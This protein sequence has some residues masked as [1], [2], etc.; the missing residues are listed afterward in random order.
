MTRDEAL[1]L[2]GSHVKADN[3]KKHCLA[4]EAI[5]LELA[6]RLEQ[7]RELWGTIGLLHDLD[8]EDTKE[9]P[10]V[11]GRKTVETPGALRP[12]RRSA[13]T[14]SCGITPKRLA[15]SGRPFSTTL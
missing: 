4:T 2:L 15:W 7:D 8:F 9:H 10:E 6:A 3:L 11:H 14:P 5:M 12:P 13:E 1:Q